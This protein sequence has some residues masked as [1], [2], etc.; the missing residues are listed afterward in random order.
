[1]SVSTHHGNDKPPPPGRGKHPLAELEGTRAIL[2]CCCC[3]PTLVLSATRLRIE[4]LGDCPGRDHSRND[5]GELTREECGDAAVAEL[6]R[7]GFAAVSLRGSEPGQ[8]TITVLEE[9]SDP[10]DAWPYEV[11]H[12]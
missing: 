7:R 6:E 2:E 12:L 10:F 3:G 1:M 8:W 5:A 4:H 9:F 11:E